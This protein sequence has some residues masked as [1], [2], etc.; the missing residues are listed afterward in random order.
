MADLILFPQARNVGK[1]RHVAAVWLSKPS[2]RDRDAYWSL[3]C[4]R[5]RRAMSRAGF[6]DET[7]MDQLDEFCRAV[8]EQIVAIDELAHPHHQD[9]DP[10]GAA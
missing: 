9:K 7:I 1:A 3:I 5:Y 6:A 2:Q 10:S 8:N 4:G